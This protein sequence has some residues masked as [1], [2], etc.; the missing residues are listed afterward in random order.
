MSN[1]DG[2]DQVKAQHPSDTCFEVPTPT[3]GL[4]PKV[5]V[6]VREEMV[7]WTEGRHPK[8]Y[9]GKSTRVGDRE[10]SL[11]PRSRLQNCP[12]S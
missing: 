5:V 1:L 11:V 6:G 8:H 12:C 3:L 10:A 4:S 9:I 7:A 2:K